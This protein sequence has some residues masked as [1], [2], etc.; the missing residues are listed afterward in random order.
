MTDSHHTIH[1]VA[2]LLHYFRAEL[3]DAFQALGLTTAEETQTYLVYLLEG[4][5]RSNAESAQTI[6]FDRPA[7]F[8]LGEAMNAA[9]ERRID[10]YRRLGDASLFSCGFFEERL[11]RTPVKSGYYR[12]MGRVAYGRLGEL[13][14]YKQPGGAFHIIFEELTRCFDVVVDAFQLVSQRGQPDHER[15]LLRWMRSGELDAADWQHLGG[16]PGNGTGEA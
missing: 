7:A 16:L 5:A 10:A 4:F 9:G 15:L 3:A 12:D 6:G 13:M 8:I 14:A 1:R 2:N 11:D